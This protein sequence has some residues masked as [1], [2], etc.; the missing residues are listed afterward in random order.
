MT[1]KQ[2]KT[3]SPEVPSANNPIFSA[4]DMQRRGERLKAEG[5]MPSLAEVLKVIKGARE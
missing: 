2:Q 1:K 4:E 3:E 5:R